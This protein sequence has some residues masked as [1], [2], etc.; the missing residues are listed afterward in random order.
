MRIYFDVETVPS[1]A[2]DARELVRATIKP[3]ATHKKPETILAWWENDAPAAIEEGYRKQSFDAS[4]GEL[5][6]ISWCDDE[7]P[8]ASTVIRSKDENEMLM[9]RRF[10]GQL[11]AHF[12]NHAIRDPQGREM[13]E[14][15]PFFIAHN[16]TFDLGFLWRR[17]IILGV[18]PTFKVPG[19]N[20]REGKDFACTMRAWSGYQGTISLD[21]LCKALKVQT[22][23]SDLDGSKVFDAWMAGELDRIAT[24]NAAD[25]IAARECWRR[26]NWEVAA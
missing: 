25:V 23:K 17:S 5:I 8:A 16:A 15:S 1:Q 21:R 18:R 22:P 7:M 24:Y 6:S 3:P 2:P 11:S 12:K 19:P 13:W 9:L 10:Y 14:D 4:V 20:A 26:I